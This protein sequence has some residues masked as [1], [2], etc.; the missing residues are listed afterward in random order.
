[1]RVGDRRAG[2]GVIQAWWWCRPPEQELLLLEHADNPSFTEF[3]F[4]CVHLWCGT[5]EKAKDLLQASLDAS[6]AA[7]NGVVS[8]EG[9]AVEEVTPRAHIPNLIISSYN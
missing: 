5:G 4:V 9:S 6:T 7:N 2:K 3:F 1:M 8:A